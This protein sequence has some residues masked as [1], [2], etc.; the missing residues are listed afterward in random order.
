MLVAIVDIMQSVAIGLIAWV[1]IKDYRARIRR[2]R[3]YRDGLKIAG[4]R[5]AN[6]ILEMDRP[7]END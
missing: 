1:V 7:A 2:M 6:P 5:I 3:S 4:N